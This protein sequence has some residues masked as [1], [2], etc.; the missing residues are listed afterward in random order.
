MK[1]LFWLA[2]LS[3]SAAGLGSSTVAFAEPSAA[4]INFCNRTSDEVMVALGYYSSGVDDGVNHN[5]L[6]GPFVSR[7]WFS[8]KANQCQ[9]F[10][11]P[12]SARY[13][14]WIATDRDVQHRPSED[15]ASSGR[16]MC[17]TGT[18]FTFEDQ[19]AS[20]DACHTDP[21]ALT[22]GQVAWVLPNKV[23][24]EVDPNVNFTGYS[25]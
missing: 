18:A 17:I 7:G 13:M 15:A 14:F 5:V 16:H 11:N 21:A 4:P 3:A 20:S 25:Y 19:N 8:V 10:P 2:L 6:T 9:V 24:T 12:F 1:L 22:K 23:D